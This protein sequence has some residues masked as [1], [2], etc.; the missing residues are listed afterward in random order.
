MAGCKFITTELYREQMCAP[1]SSAPPP[2]SRCSAAHRCAAFRI[3]LN[4]YSMLYVPCCTAFIL[5]VVLTVLCYVYLRPG[6]YGAMPM[7]TAA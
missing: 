2:S 6:L 5:E 4:K 7:G 3:F 1:T